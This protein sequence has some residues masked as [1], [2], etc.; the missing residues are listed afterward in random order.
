MSPQAVEVLEEWKDEAKLR[1]AQADAAKALEKELKEFS[2][3]LPY[4]LARVIE[5][6]QDGFRLGAQGFYQGGLGLI[7]IE[8]HEGVE[9]FPQLLDQYF[10]GISVSGA[11]RYMKVARALSNHPAFK[12]FIYERG[13]YSKAL[14][15]IEA[16]TTEEIG[17]FEATG[18]LRE[19]TQDEID[20]MSVRQLKRAL[21]RVKEKQAEA[22]KKA[23][24]KVEAENAE[25]SA[26]VEALKA[27]LA[28][29]ELAAAKKVFGRMAQKMGE[30]LGLARKLDIKLLAADWITR[31]KT[32]QELARVENLIQE[33]QARIYEVEEPI[34]PQMVGPE[35]IA[36]P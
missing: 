29:A 5:R 21:R 17:D 25:L 1:S 31:I 8:R 34:A 15:L 16:C 11:Y 4:D 19:F 2:G 22:V 12:T 3:G 27:A 30:I 6:T 7:L 24:E 23:T 26:E 10:P 18:Q 20:K 33:L 9:T 28:P 36:E 32:L 13:A 35:E 14:T